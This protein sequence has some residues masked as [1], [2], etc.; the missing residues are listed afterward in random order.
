VAERLKQSQ[1]LART[2]GSLK[3]K[4]GTV[5]RSVVVTSFAAL[6]REVGRAG[7]PASAPELSPFSGHGGA[8]SCVAFSPDGKRAL[9]RRI[10]SHHAGGAVPT[11]PTDRRG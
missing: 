9:S 6:A 5:R 1:A 3:V 7:A 8:V 11:R 10:A 4:G 2:L